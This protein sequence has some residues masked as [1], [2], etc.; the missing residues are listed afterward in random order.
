MHT[1][2]FNETLKGVSPDHLRYSVLGPVTDISF[3]EE[4]RKKFVTESAY[5]DGRPRA[6][7]R[8]LAEANLRQII[9]REESHVDA[10]EARTQL[11]DR[12][13]EIFSGKTLEVVAFPGGSF[14][15]PD[16]IADGRPKLVILA[17]DG[18]TVGSSIE[19][20][21]ELIKRIFSRKGAEGS[22]L[23]MLRNNLV[24]V[25]ADDA[26]KDEMRRKTNRRLALQEM[27]KP[28]RLVDLAEHQQ[29][30][31]REMEA[32]SE[33]ELAIAIQQCYRHVLYPSRARVGTSDVDLAHSAIDIHSASDQP[34]AGQQQIV[35]AL[36]NLNKL[37]LSEDEPDSPVYVRDRTPLRKGQI[38]TL[39]LRDEF[40]R[41][42]ALPILVGDDIFVRGVRN[43][44]EHG[45]YVYQRGDLLFGPGDPPASIMIDEQS[46]IFTMA[47]A[48]NIGIWPR[49]PVDP[50]ESG[51][52]EV[53]PPDGPVDPPPGVDTA[54]SFAAE[55]VLR[56][57]LVKIWEQAGARKIAELE[58]LT[59]RMFESG[60]GFRLLGAVGAVSGAGKR[61]AITGSYETR[62]GGSFELEFHGPVLDA[63]PVREFLEP[64]LRDATSSNMEIRFDLNFENGLT[65]QGDAAEKLTERFCRFANGA[66]YVAAVAE[67]KK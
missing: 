20:I 13:R 66:A 16:E 60:D 3:I 40:R 61:V 41:D 7:M 50:P 46:V 6:P 9:R 59:I 44:I 21:P 54:S 64:Q 31:V 49:Q 55:G 19:Y 24:F 28:E 4:A 53:D 33:Q 22:A 43:G 10:G 45:E 27:K 36:R 39:S 42:P 17:Y 51:G 38:T 2:A 12:I 63:Q 26:R 57:A 14:D 30:Q 32:R 25:V 47:C 15:V 52:N 11:N 1:L 58:I 48:R 35:R 5:L 23:R 29:A 34:G 65:M 62:E 37:R 56:E 8:F 18:V 67:V